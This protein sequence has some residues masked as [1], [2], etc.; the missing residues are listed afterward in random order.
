M[1]RWILQLIKRMG[2]R[3]EV[4]GAHPAKSEAVTKLRA[5]ALT[6]RESFHVE[7]EFR[8]RERL[9]SALGPRQSRVQCGSA[10]YFP[11]AF[12][13]IDHHCQADLGLGSLQA[14]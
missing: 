2:Y 13:V 1:G 7:L 10:Q 8:S 5:G 12:E 14:S 3:I 9:P 6:S 4:R 11:H